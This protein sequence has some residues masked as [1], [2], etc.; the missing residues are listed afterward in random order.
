MRGHLFTGV[1]LAAVTALGLCVP[2][3]ADAGSPKLRPRPRSSSMHSFSKSSHGFMEDAGNIG[4]SAARTARVAARS[5]PQR[6]QR[7]D[8]HHSTSQSSPFGAVLGAAA[9]LGYAYWKLRNVARFLG[10]I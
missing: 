7:N 8:G 3:E 4:L 5:A 2:H 10:V 1:V 9:V 6:D